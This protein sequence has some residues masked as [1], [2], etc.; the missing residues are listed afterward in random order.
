ML[1]RAERGVVRR[2]AVLLLP[3]ILQATTRASANLGAQAGVAQRAVLPRQLVP[4]GSRNLRPLHCCLVL[5]LCSLVK[6]FRNSELVLDQFVQNTSPQVLSFS[7]SR[8][9]EIS[10]CSC[11]S[12]ANSDKVKNQ[13]E[14]YHVLSDSAVHKLHKYG[15]A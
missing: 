2:R 12:T 14:K 4:L 15:S 3:C 1:A 11:L 13:I 5:L 10:C 8:G 7:D 6:V 9:S